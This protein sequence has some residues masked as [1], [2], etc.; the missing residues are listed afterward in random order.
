[1]NINK[2]PHAILIKGLVIM[3]CGTKG[4]AETTAEAC[5][6][7][8]W[9]FDPEITVVKATEK[10]YTTMQAEEVIIDSFP[11]IYDL[12]AL[13]QFFDFCAIQDFSLRAV[14]DIVVK[15]ISRVKDQGW[16][17]ENL[18]RYET[19]TDLTKAL[20]NAKPDWFIME[21]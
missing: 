16:T 12:E 21:E 15:L 4:I 7:V 19:L 8:N 18:T 2:K 1:M 17:K 5:Y 10:H 3:I 14:S 13:V 6:G 20:R 11:T 9:E